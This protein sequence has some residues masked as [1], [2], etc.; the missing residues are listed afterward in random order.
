MRMFI[1]KSQVNGELR[2]FAADQGGQQ[3]PKQFAPWHAV[4]VVREDKA[5]PHNLNR[6][7]IEKAIADQGFQLFRTKAKKSAAG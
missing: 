1:F 4:G 5:P 2:A 3:L 7:V 6:D